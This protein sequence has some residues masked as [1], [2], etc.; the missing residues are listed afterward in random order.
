MDLYDVNGNILTVGGIT[1][2]QYGAKGDGTTDDTTAVQ[3]AF[4]ASSSQNAPVVFGYGKTYAVSSAITMTKRQ[5]VYGNGSV[6]KATASM[7][8]VLVINTENQHAPASLGKGLLT[9][10]T[11]DCNQI[12][13]NGIYVQYS[14]GFAIQNVD[15]MSPVQNGIY[16]YSGF[17]IFCTNCRVSNGTA[18]TVG[19]NIQTSDCHF[20]DIVT[21]NVG[22]GVLVAKDSNFFERVHCWNTETSIV[23]TSIMFDVRA[24][25]YIFNSYADTCATCVKVTGAKFVFVNG[26]KIYA[27]STFMPSSIMTG[28]TPYLFYM[29][30]SASTSK[31][32]GFGILY[33]SNIQFAFSNK[34]AS[35]WTGFSWQENNDTTLTN[36]SAVPT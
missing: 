21:V 1:P 36:M 31:V 19:F 6:I 12:A 23:P 22:T 29:G 9:N 15:V 10:L 4:T 33:S 13:N 32:K 11:V 30:T 34:S 14:A 2:E 5:D 8:K 7:D 17:E 24:N 18:N 28:I 35:S 25:V 20:T 27:T 3:A 26:L 16:L